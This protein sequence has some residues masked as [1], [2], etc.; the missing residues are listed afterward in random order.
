MCR[1]KLNIKNFL[2]SLWSP[3]EE[4]VEFIR[5][6]RVSGVMPVSLDETQ[7]YL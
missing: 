4:A 7:D 1:G 2:T 3:R 6:A 5:I